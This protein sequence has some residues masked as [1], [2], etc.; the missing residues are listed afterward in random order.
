M[1]YIAVE[2]TINL[3]EWLMALMDL[4]KDMKRKLPV[5]TTGVAPGDAS[6]YGVIIMC[7]LHA[8][9]P[10]WLVE[11]DTDDAMAEALD[12]CAVDVENGEWGVLPAGYTIPT[13]PS[14]MTAASIIVRSDAMIFA[15]YHPHGDRPCE[16]ESQTLTQEELVSLCAQLLN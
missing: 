4:V 2:L 1:K 12:D 3:C 13:P 5:F 8:F 14:E 7:N 11:D 6:P 10:D 16:I 15:G 9:H